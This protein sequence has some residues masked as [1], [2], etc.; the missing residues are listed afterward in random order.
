[1]AMMNTQLDPNITFYRR[2]VIKLSSIDKYEKSKKRK[3]KSG[4]CRS[5]VRFGFAS[6]EGD[7]EEN[8]ITLF[9]ANIRPLENLITILENDLG[10]C[11][12][13]LHFL[14]QD[15]GMIDK[16]VQPGDIMTFSIPGRIILVTATCECPCD[17]GEAICDFEAN[18]S[19]TEC[20]CC[21]NS[22]NH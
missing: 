11:P 2:Q 1:M 3:C 6:F 7:C 12:V 10:D 21:S 22:Y 15:G 14:Q 20:I 4:E 13:T 18:F 8:N 19:Y 17:S 5:V 9:E 16:T